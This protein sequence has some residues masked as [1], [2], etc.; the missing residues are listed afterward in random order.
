MVRFLLFRFSMK[1]INK[2][3]F[4]YLFAILSSLFI[5]FTTV[6]C[7]EKGDEP[8]TP[9]SN[10]GRRTVLVYIVARNNLGSSGFDSADIEEMIRGVSDG[11]LGDDDRL[12]VFHESFSGDVALKEI[13]PNGIV[14]LKQ[15]DASTSGIEASTMNR[16][17]NDVEEIAP[18]RSYGLV[19][20]SHATGWIEDGI[21]DD[22][23][24]PYSVST[25]SF[26][27]SGSKKMNIK[28]LASV[29]EQR[30]LDFIYFDCCYMMGIEALYQ[31]RN[32]APIIAGSPTEIPSEGMPYQDNLKYFFSSGD[33]DI[34]SAATSTFSHY[35]QL[36][37]S[38]RTCTMSVIRTSE[39]PKLAR[40]TKSIFQLSSAGMPEHPFDPQRYM[41]NSVS[42][43]NYFDFA[44]YIRELAKDNPSL[45]NE[46]NNALSDV[47][48]Y[49]DATPWLWN[50]VALK[51]HSGL[52]T[53]I[54]PS[55]ESSSQRGYDSLDW[56]NDA[57]KFLNK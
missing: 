16:I 35:N 26:G 5:A 19:L 24:D 20:W 12:I 14:T 15:Y 11:A 50:T 54:L 32:C 21:K 43:C 38:A 51:H 48:V 52:S 33:A 4:T 31:L 42:T 22:T 37:G 18:A 10:T 49:E 55:Y 7:S 8:D 45:L 1:L 40:I 39:L 23:F 46:F 27:L 34:I 53:Y 36:S 41:T 6:S 3:I 17:F 9:G 56:W 47:V 29:L 28:T 2:N 25:L 13:T 44:Q 57:A 30:K